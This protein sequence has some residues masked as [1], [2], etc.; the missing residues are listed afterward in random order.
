MKD[1]PGTT[2]QKEA[3][4]SCF[5]MLD[6]SKDAELERLID[7]SILVELPQGKQ[8]FT[9]G[10]QCEHYLLVTEGIVR[11]QKLAANGREI[12]LYRV[13][14]GESCILTTSCL[15]AGNH[16][17]AEGLTETA[18]TAL[19]IPG[20][21]FHQV[22]NQSESFRTFVMGNFSYRMADLLSLIEDVT[23][24]RLDSRLAAKLIQLADQHTQLSITHQALAVELGSAREVISRV[25]KDF[26]RRGWI[27]LGRGTISLRDYPELEALAQCD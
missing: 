2:R 20:S 12:V 11:V 8:V 13:R 27:E 4:S 9:T 10:M 3:W 14:K 19:A 5:P 21:V 17:P 22:M 24:R 26:E 23:F 25:L 1:K 18:V 15:I 7:S 6:P 16:Y